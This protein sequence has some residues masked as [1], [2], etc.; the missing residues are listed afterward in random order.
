MALIITLLVVGAILLFLEILC[1][2]LTEQLKE[3]SL[4]SHQKTKK[5]I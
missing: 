2:R 1:F 3:Y 5:L 4:L